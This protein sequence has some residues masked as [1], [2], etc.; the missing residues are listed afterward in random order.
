MERE[1]LMRSLALWAG[2]R[3][4]NEAGPKAWTSP[5]ECE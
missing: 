5:I 1:V 4:D 3:W 2:E